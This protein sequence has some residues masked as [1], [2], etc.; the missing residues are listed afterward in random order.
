MFVSAVDG[1]GAGQADSHELPHAYC[2]APGI[3][4]GSPD[5]GRPAWPAAT[6]DRWPLL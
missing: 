2:R 1:G 6:Y 4:A 5:C 3:T